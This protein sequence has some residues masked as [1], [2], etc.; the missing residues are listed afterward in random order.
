M[1]KPKSK[2]QPISERKRLANQRNAQ[3]S[4]GPKT[5]E[6]KARSKMNALLHGVFCQEVLLM[7]EDAN[8]LKDLR[9]EFIR[10]LKPQRMI[11][12]QLVDKIVDCC[13]KQRR[14][15]VS[16]ATEH[17]AE[18]RSELESVGETWE[19]EMAKNHQPDYCAPVAMTRM[20]D[21]D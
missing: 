5:P 16:E 6:G 9:R 18:L 14:L 17:E 19:Q 8:L 7:K 2:K 12:L 10:D 20:M 4:T 21:R 13:W 3:K 15:R 1:P 11:E